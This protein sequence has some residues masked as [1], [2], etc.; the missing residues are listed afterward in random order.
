MISQGASATLSGKQLEDKV[1]DLL[2]EL[3]IAYT[4]Q[5]KFTDCY[6]NSRSRMDFMVGDMAIECKRQEVGG[7]ADQ[8]MPF[9][10]E[11]LCLFNKG[12][13]VLDGTHFKTR[14]GIQ[15]YLNKRKSTKF[16]W[17]FIEDLKGWLENNIC[18]DK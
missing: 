1:Q 3:G 10:Y 15:D 8:K 2:E 11:N 16:D 14:K 12:L 17:C 5:V 9:V 7:T 6:G 18:Q 4:S 13:L